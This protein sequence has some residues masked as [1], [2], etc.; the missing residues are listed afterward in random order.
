[1]FC[2]THGTADHCPD[3]LCE[4]LDERY[5]EL[6]AENQR[7]KALLL[8]AAGDI[9]GWGAYAGEYFQEKHGLADDVKRYREAAL[10]EKGK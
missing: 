2:E 6:L 3:C 10:Q 5:A 1:M 7:L 9:E 8:E 4:I